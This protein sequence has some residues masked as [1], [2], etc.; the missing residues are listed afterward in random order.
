M[1]R[2][3]SSNLLGL[4]RICFCFVGLLCFGG[5][6]AQQVLR[7]GADPS[8]GAPYVFNDPNHPDQY[9]GYEKEMV[10]VLAAAMGRKPEFVPS[11]WETLVS[12]LQRGS[13][14]V[15]VNGLEPTGDRAK[16]IQFSKP[17][18]VF[19]LALTVRVNEQQIHSLA[20][21]RNRVV[22]TLGNTAASRLLQTEGVP[23]KGYA[24]PV[25]AYRDLELK[26]IDAVLMDVPAEVY[27]VSKSTTLKRATEPFFRGTYNIGLRKGDDALKT[28]ID[29][30]IDKIIRDGSLEQIL[31]KWGLWNDAQLELQTP[32]KAG[33]AN[34]NNIQYEM[35]STSFNWRE[36]LWRLARA[37]LVTVLIAFGS[38]CIALILG[39]PLAMGQSKGPPWLR[40]LCTVYI[41]FFRGTPVLVQLLFLYFGLPTIGLAMPG[42]LTALVGLGLNYAAYES[43]VYRAALE[44][45]PRGQWEASYLLGMNPLLAF[46]RIILPQAFRI[47]LPAMTNDF[48]S[49]FKDTSV[50]YAISVW[51]LATAYREL[52][53]ASGQFLLLGA[54]VSIFYLAMSLPMAH[55]ARRLERR[56]QNRQVDAEPV[57]LEP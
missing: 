6:N 27:Y 38:M 56:L 19:Q 24:D 15:I 5:A 54:A 44:A 4:I 46:R 31:R 51:E 28:E 47:A 8:G 25:A 42:W 17:Y 33:Q 48:V 9:I 20:D 39:M 29:A 49:L 37:A 26:R 52:A 23:F 35:T 10:D 57:A 12:T 41:E 13:F 55:L 30:A 45:I 11:D 7:W 3:P 1:K 2:S 43:Q 36:A 21:C 22:G 40:W 53:N 32:P 18:Y 50:A 16:Q 34:N 14:D